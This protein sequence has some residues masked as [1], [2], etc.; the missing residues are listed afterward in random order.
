MS[1]NVEYAILDV[2]EGQWEY[3][4]VAYP[5]EETQRKMKL[6]RLPPRLIER[7]AHGY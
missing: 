4:R 3:R 2:E 1:R 5:V 7:L 6:H